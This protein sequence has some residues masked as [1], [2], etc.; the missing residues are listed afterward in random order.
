MVDWFKRQAPIRVKFRNPGPGPKYLEISTGRTSEADAHTEAAKIVEQAVRG[1]LSPLVLVAATLAY[2]K[3]E[4]LSVAPYCSYVRAYMR[5][6][7]ETLPLLAAGQ[8][9]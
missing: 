7:P 4:G 5:R 3:A 9:V 8:Q 2:A 1:P 6:H